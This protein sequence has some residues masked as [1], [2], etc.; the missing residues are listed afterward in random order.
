LEPS[1][2]IIVFEGL[3]R[4]VRQVVKRQLLEG[5]KIGKN[6]ITTSML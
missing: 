4:M 2:F 6:D 1:L 3:V 5:V